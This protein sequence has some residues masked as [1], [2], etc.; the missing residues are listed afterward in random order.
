MAHKYSSRYPI[1][2]CIFIFNIQMKQLDVI[3]DDVDTVTIAGF[4]LYF[5]LLDNLGV[6]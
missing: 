4:N 2:S 1:Y 3:L 6:I 5:A